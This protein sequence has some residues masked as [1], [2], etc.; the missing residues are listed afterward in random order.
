MRREASRR[1]GEEVLRTYALRASSWYEQKEWLP[2]AIEAAWLAQDMER[3]A[4]LIEQ[5]HE[6]NFGSPQT[7][8]RW[9]EQLPEAVL[10]VHPLLCFLF[11]TELHTKKFRPSITPSP[12]LLRF[13]PDY[14]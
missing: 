12:Q 10:R 9:L 2:E 3:V 5:V 14:G 11:A 7:M 1:L 6:Q 4:R 13:E 8:L